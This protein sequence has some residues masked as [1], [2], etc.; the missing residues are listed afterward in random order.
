M[1]NPISRQFVLALAI[2]VAGAVGMARAQEMPSA[3]N[4]DGRE[5]SDASLRGL[6]LFAATGYDIVGGA[7]QPKAIL[8]EIRFNGD[9]TLTVPA[10][11]VSRNGTILHP[12]ASGT[13][14][15]AVT[16]DCT[17]TLTFASGLTFDLY[18][19]PRSADFS[20]IQ[21]NAGSVLQGRVIRLSR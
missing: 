9:G 11:T 16:S 20:M 13:G 19:G 5:C 4:D 7:A 3:Q 2:A 17:G 15:Y 6:Y 8:E 1:R 18:L 10:A 21:T 12:P 14:T